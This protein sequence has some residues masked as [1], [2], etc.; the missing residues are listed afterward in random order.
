MCSL[1]NSQRFAM[2]DRLAAT[3]QLDAPVTTIPGVSSGRAA[4]LSRLG[5][6]TIRE[7]LSRYPRR[8]LD[9]SKIT[10]IGSAAIGEN[11]TIAA[12]V[13]EAVLK[14]PK[15]KFD[16]VEVTLTDGTGTL[17]CTFFKQPWLVKTLAPGMRVSVAGKVEFNYGFLRMTMPFLDK[18]DG[19]NV[20][21]VTGQVIPVHAASEKVPVGQMRR[22]VRA[23]L[24]QLGR[25]YDPLPA[26]L[27][28]KYRLMPR[29]EALRAIHFPTNMAEQAQARRRL[30]YEELFSLEVHLMQK[31]LASIGGKKACEHRTNGPCKQAFLSNLSFALTEDQQHAVEDISARMAAPKRM[32]H[33][34]LG[35]VG[36]GKTIVAAIALCMAADSDSQALMMGP[37][38]VLVDQYAN[39]LGPQLEAAGITWAKLTGSTPSA[40]RATILEGLASGSIQICFGTHALLTNDV[41][42]AKCSLVVIDEE[43]RFGV[44]QRDALISK[45]LAPDILEMTAT[46]IPRTLALALYGSMTQSYLKSVP[47]K[48]PP[49]TTKVFNFRERGKAYDIALDACARGEQV[50]IVCPLVSSSSQNERATRK[51]DEPKPSSKTRF[52]WSGASG[53][54]DDPVYIDSL[55]DFDGADSKAAEAQAKFLQSKTFSAYRVGLLHGRMK[56]DAKRATMERFRSGEIDVLVSTTVI[57][58]GVDVPNA[59]VM[60]VEDADKFGLSQL[61]QL[62]GR[63]GRGSKPGHM[64]LIA[65]TSDASAC[66]RLAAMER[67]EDG[68]ELAECDLSLRREGDILGNR[69]SGASVLKLVNVIRDGAI[70]EAAHADAREFLEAQANKNAAETRIVLREIDAIFASES[71]ERSLKKRGG[72]R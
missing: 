60:I 25:V 21:E 28:S 22:I 7:L 65:A 42:C 47:F 40:D 34:L 35:D 30:A 56:A 70:I 63:V 4:A 26:S 59:T 69:Q 14:R 68:F 52:G 20:E 12:T 32:R 54:D 1:S 5:A 38:E 9:M 51:Q 10:T 55:E 50:Y 11:A 64:C 71:Q 53:I 45:G 39:G 66:E 58:V 19:D 49:R 17:I 15:P 37:T 67:T 3:L 57:E 33:M 18:I 6:T 27:R 36:T 62:R 23:A 8:Y 44:D 72:T 61:H 2:S 46:P 43:Q 16:L 41:V 13:H 48:R 29:A 24:T 31:E